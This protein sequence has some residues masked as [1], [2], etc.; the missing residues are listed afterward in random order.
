MTYA[1]LILMLLLTGAGLT[2]VL[3]RLMA[4]HLLRPP[5]MTDSKALYI[6]NRLTPQDL[7]LPYQP[8][9]FEVQD[10]SDATPLHLS[11][12]WIPSETESD[13]T[14]LILHGYSDAKVGGI[15]WAPVWRSLGFHVLAIDLRAHGESGGCYSTAGFYERHDVCQVLDQIRRQKPHE[16]RSIVIFG[17]SLGATVAAAVGCMQ[18]NLTA[19]ILESPY[20]DYKNAIVTHGRRLAMPLEWGYP[21]AYR[22]AKRLGRADFDQVRPIDLIP[23]IDCPVLVIHSGSDT[24]VSPDQQARIDQALSRRSGSL[25]SRSV[26][27]PDAQHT[28]GLL[29]DPLA[30]RNLLKQFLTDIRLQAGSEIQQISPSPSE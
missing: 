16:T 21:I 6:L 9:N 8:C 15:A 11:G 1:P 3:L 27:I 23:N 18:K 5:R 13:Q 20:D 29:Q 4:G 26:V 22:W 12:W 7:E 25:V 28:R 19:V 2:V 17:V 14:V 30:Y 24:F 10:V